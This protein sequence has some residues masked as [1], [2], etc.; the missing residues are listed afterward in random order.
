MVLSIFLMA[1][2]G[3]SSVSK[4]ASGPSSSSS[5]SSGTSGSSSSSDSQTTKPAPKVNFPTKN[6]NFVIPVSPGGGFDTIS[7]MF[8]PYW[9]KALPN[10]I[11]IVPQNKPGAQWE[12]GIRAIYDAKPN[13]Y[14][15]G[16]LNIP[17]NS[18]N[19][20]LGKAH[21]DLSK[22]DYIGQITDVNYVL[23]ASKKS[24]IKTFADLK[25]SKKTLKLGVVGLS[26]SSGV[27]A[28]VAAK[29]FGINVN[30]INHDG[31]AQVVLAASRGSVDYLQLPYSSIKN[32]IKSGDLVP[33]LTFGDQRLPELP[34]VPTAAEK[35]YSKLS[36]VVRMSRVVAAPPG[37]PP[38]ILK[39]LRDSFTKALGNPDFKKQLL[40]D[41]SPYDPANY[42]HAATSA[43][44]SLTQFEQYKSLLKKYQ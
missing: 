11:K 13:G 26:S 43:K 20:I 35:G 36:S 16:I 21:Y 33:I 3:A 32:Q 23:A 41:G 19:Q 31:S 14:T 2:C 12:L 30:P 25:N 29:A 27:G 34:N 17:G 22:F 39:I 5:G 6:I 18:V 10:N 8:I 40:K 38:A 37:T 15:L 42:Q 1:G 24:G 28:L 9:E 7:R 4:S 44:D